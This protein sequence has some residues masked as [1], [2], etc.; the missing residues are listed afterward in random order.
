MW[1][2][3]NWL[4]CALRVATHFVSV[5]KNRCVRDLWDGNTQRHSIESVAQSRAYGAIY[6]MEKWAANAWEIFCNEEIAFQTH[7]W[8]KWWWWCA[9][10]MMRYACNF[11]I[12]FG[13]DLCSIKHTGTGRQHIFSWRPHCFDTSAPQSS[14]I[15]I[16]QL[17]LM[18]PIVWDL[19]ETANELSLGKR[20]WS[21][22]HLNSPCPA[23]TNTR[24]YAITMFLRRIK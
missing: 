22:Q 4:G 9:L 8:L 23:H 3:N 17:C 12:A 24:I 14:S 16:R 1:S 15:D 7:G 2:N 5:L 10:M 11:L 19:W 6:Q 20:Q 21:R 18:L 13:R